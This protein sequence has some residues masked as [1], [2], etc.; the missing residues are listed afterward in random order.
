MFLDSKNDFNVL[1]VP[2]LRR[3][4]TTM[5]R[6]YKSEELLLLFKNFARQGLMDFRCFLR[7]LSF[8]LPLSSS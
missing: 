6:M 4:M 2:E 3:A 5:Q 1:E 7:R 8:F